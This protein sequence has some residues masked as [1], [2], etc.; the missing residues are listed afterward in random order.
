MERLTGL[1]LLTLAFT[2]SA[3]QTE[4]TPQELFDAYYQG[5]YPNEVQQ[6]REGV[7]SQTIQEEIF[8]LY[9]QGR[10][11][12]IIP[13]IDELQT[14]QQSPNYM[15]YF[16]KAQTYLALN[17]YQAAI[18][19]FSKIPKNNVWYEKTEWYLAL[20]YLAQSQAAEARIILERIV[21]K[22]AD[23]FRLKEAQQ[24]LRELSE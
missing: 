18:S 20:C 8:K 13:I 12:Q 19:E 11:E 5:P 6:I 16:Y 9:E 7:A 3:C 1:L 4:R 10:F 21:A 17:Y 22:P 24:L 23:Y 2:M 15:G 14:G